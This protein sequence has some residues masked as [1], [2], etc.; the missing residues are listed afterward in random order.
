MGS[1]SWA[2]RYAPNLG[3][4]SLDTPLFPATVG[5]HDPVEHIAFAEAHGFAGVE[6]NFLKLRP[7][8]EQERIGRELARRELEMGCFVNNPSS[9]NLPLWSSPDPGD[10]AVVRA[11]LASSIEA[12]HRVNGRVMTTLVGRSEA[13]PPV[14]QK[15]ALVENLKRLAP[16]AEAGG[17]VIGIEACNAR[18][19]PMLLIDDVTEACMIARAVDS[20]AVR[21]V[22]DIFHVQ[23]RGGDVINRLH[24]CW[25]MVAA[26][27]VADNPGR[28]EMGSGELNWAN[29][30][31]HIRD[32]GYTGLIELEHEIT[33]AGMAGEQCMLDRL[34]AIDSAIGPAIDG[35][36]NGPC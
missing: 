34:A 26:I 29:V 17:M 27:Q 36:G 31:Q 1:K 16:L 35:E 12:A 33:G 5:S 32:L 8:A 23:A 19:Y 24:Q 22:F 28:G 13:I 9:W 6:D 3:L 25:D 20:P 21:I 14:A 11:E 4:N 30:L 7:V 2:M 15:A 10:R 18:D